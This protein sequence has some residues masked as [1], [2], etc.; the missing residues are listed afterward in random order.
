VLAHILLFG[1]YVNV[2]YRRHRGSWPLRDA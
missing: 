2:T 1:C